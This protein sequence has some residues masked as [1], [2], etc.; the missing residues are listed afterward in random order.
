MALIPCPKC[1]EMISDKA[2]VC[3]KCGCEMGEPTPPAPTAPVRTSAPKY[4]TECG[5]PLNEG[6]TVCSQCGCPIPNWQSTPDAVPFAPPAEPVVMPKHRKMKTMTIVLIIIGAIV[7]LAGVAA[8]IF[9]YQYMQHQKQLEIEEAS[10]QAEIQR[11]REYSEKLK[12]TR[13]TMYTG[14]VKSEEAGNLIKQVWYNSIFEEE[15]PETDRFTKPNGTF[16]EDFNDALDN[17][18]A[19]SEFHDVIFGI[20]LNQK[21]VNALM[22]ELTDPPEQFEEAYQELKKLHE[23]YL[24]LTNLVMNPTGS[25]KTFSQEFSDADTKTATCLKKMDV[26]IK[27]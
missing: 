3:M 18:F 24:E 19:D 20:N 13:N 8:G 22:Q 14:A 26:Y 23:A 12:R 5:A 10:R 27:E 25:L 17:L 4:C 21:Q 9:G 15:N 6:Q 2:S 1:G 11:I 16:V 7:V